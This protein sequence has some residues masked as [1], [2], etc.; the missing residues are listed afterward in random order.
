MFSG[1]QS[2]AKFTDQKH[3]TGGLGL[4]LRDNTAKHGLGYTGVNI[5]QTSTPKDSSEKA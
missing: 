3:R 2:G 4:G 5:R 1:L